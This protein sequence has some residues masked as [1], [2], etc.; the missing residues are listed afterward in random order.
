MNTFCMQFIEN[1]AIELHILKRTPCDCPNRILDRERHL[2]HSWM[3]DC[4]LDFCDDFGAILN[5]NLKRLV[6][7][8]YCLTLETSPERI[9]EVAMWSTVVEFVP[10]PL[11]QKL[12]EIMYF[13]DRHVFSPSVLHSFDNAIILQQSRLKQRWQSILNGE[14]MFSGFAELLSSCSKSCTA[15]HEDHEHIESE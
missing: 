11:P 10:N 9:F 1:R 15:S 5:G 13:F 7:S 8:L 3:G 4:D 14:A 6:S 12:D 2:S